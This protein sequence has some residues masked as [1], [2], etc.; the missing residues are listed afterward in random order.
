[1]KP[2]TSAANEA[3]TLIDKEK[4]R[5][6]FIRKLSITAWSVTFVIVLLF[7]VVTGAQVVQNLKY[8]EAGTLTWPDVVGSAMPLVVVLGTISL[9]IATLS[10]VGIFLRLRTA[11]LVE[12][13]L[14]LAAL[15][16]MLRS[17]PDAPA[18]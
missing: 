15:E 8:F 11:S 1:M 2:D 9:L 13:Q 7:G 17:K 4:R 5:D 16:D 3:W 18:R 12:I 10:T 6:R 14:R